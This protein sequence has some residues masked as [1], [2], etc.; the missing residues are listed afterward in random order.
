MAIPQ[1]VDVLRSLLRF[2]EEQATVQLHAPVEWTTRFPGPT[3]VK[4]FRLPVCWWNTGQQI[5]VKHARV[6]V[7]RDGEW[8]L[9]YENAALSETAPHEVVWP[10]PIV[11]RAFRFEA[12]TRTHPEEERLT[13][14]AGAK[15]VA[16]M[17]QLIGGWPDSFK[18]L[19]NAA[20]ETVVEPWAP[21][22]RA[23]DSSE[24][25]APGIKLTR[26]GRMAE[27]DNGWL[28]LGLSLER[29]CLRSFSWDPEKTGRQTKDLLHQVTMA[30][31]ARN[32]LHSAPVLLEPERGVDGRSLGCARVELRG[33]GVRYEGIELAPEVRMDAAWKLDRDGAEL[34]LVLDVAGVRR[35]INWEAWRW[36]FDLKT[37]VT[38]CLAK[39]AHAL[40]DGSRG[41]CAFPAIWHAPNF[42]NLRVE[43]A[44]GDPATTF[45]RVET[46]RKESLAWFGVELGVVPRADGDVDVLPGKHRAVV[47]FSRGRFEGGGGS[48]AAFRRAWASHFGFRPE[49]YGLSNNAGAT[50]CLFCLWEYADL[51]AATE[52]G[53]ARALALEMCRFT[54][55]LA[56]RGGAGYGWRR[57]A[58]LDTASSLLIAA[59]V[60]DAGDSSRDWLR[61]AWPALWREAEFLLGRAD[62]RGLVVAPLLTG[63]RGECK[64]SSNWWDVVCFGHHDAYCNILAWRALRL[65]ARMAARVGKDAEASRCRA[66]ADRLRAAFGPTFWNPTTGWL[67]G[68]RSADGELHDHAFLFI[69]GL[70]VAFGL[71]EGEQARQLLTR[72]EAKRVEAGLDR[73]DYGLPGNLEPVPSDST[74]KGHNGRRADGSDVF[75]FYENG[76]LTMSMAYGYVR[77]LGKHGFAVV[78]DMEDQMLASF[79]AGRV[80][81]G[82][83]AGIDWRWWDGTPCGY[84]GILVDQ[85][86][87]LLAIA[88]NRGLAPELLLE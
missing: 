2:P 87:V 64:W 5:F 11:G 3:Q 28:Q 49:H 23:V 65:T 36:V 50:N 54:L 8:R 14:Y 72:L 25:S 66:A 26:A 15:E 16:F 83:H 52:P 75:G 46:W 73:F 77:A 37:A 53:E 70:A 35:A 61:A 67:G 38:A 30:R 20:G 56:L 88:Q 81:G 82:L 34:T 48:H 63:N 76:G 58:F 39:P 62:E 78:R 19:A 40:A 18:W 55:D 47:R 45:L 80:L 60:V 22:A 71:V 1:A 9:I 57:E 42:G 29:P 31:T 41:R 6:R 32:R 59:A 27:F 84:E 10:E 24:P 85:L 44:E 43:L 74:P 79:E 68:W 33:D 69:N 86:Q 13:M 51:A 17:N 7:W 4:G 12:V 21:P